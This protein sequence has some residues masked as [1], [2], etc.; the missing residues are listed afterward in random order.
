MAGKR[1]K[2][3]PPAEDRTIDIFSGKTAL[4]NK[5][6]A[7]QQEA[8]EAVSKKGELGPIDFH[9][10]AVR[11]FTTG[12]PTKDWTEYQYTVAEWNNGYVVYAVGGVTDKGYPVKFN[13]GMYSRTSLERLSKL[14]VEVLG[15]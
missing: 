3:K 9:S 10:D 5:L 12:K 11:W 4:E 6:E 2:Q 14:L 7:E 15:G 8:S 1:K 13:C